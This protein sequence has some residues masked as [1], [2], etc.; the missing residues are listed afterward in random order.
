MKEYWQRSTQ[1]SQR[2]TTHDQPRA[3]SPINDN[4]CL[5]KLQEGLLAGSQNST[6]E[7]TMNTHVNFHVVK[8]VHAAPGHSQKRE[9]SPGLAGCYSQRKYKLKYVK[10]VSCVTQ[11]SCVKPV[12]N[13]KNVASNLPVGAR[14]SRIYLRCT[15]SDIPVQGTAIR[16]V[17]S[18]HGV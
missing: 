6:Q 13:V 18:T 1:E 14:L 4:Y 15:G 2:E 10:G 16:F 5:N 9:I 7:Q 17:Q 8:V 12:T 3:S 11:L